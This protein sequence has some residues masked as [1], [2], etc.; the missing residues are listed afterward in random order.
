MKGINK[1]NARE[2]WLSRLSLGGKH[3]LIQFS[4]NCH[5]Y[6]LSSGG[7]RHSERSVTMVPMI[8][9]NFSFCSVFL[10]KYFSYFVFELKY[11]GKG[12]TG[13]EVPF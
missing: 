7:M 5:H 10:G 4:R 11:D 13:P 8:F 12:Q 2:Q 6:R 3:Y 1:F 9:S